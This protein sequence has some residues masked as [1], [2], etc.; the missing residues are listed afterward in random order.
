M[1]EFANVPNSEFKGRLYFI[2]A[3][4]NINDEN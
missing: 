3:S 4:I 1:A 2:I